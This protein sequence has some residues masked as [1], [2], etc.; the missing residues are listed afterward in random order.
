[1]YIFILFAMLFGNTS[2]SNNNNQAQ[3]RHWHSNPPVNIGG[4]FNKF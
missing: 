1:M 2:N 4:G 3:Q